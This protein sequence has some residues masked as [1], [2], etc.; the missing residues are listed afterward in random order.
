MDEGGRP[1]AMKKPMTYGEGLMSDDVFERLLTRETITRD[2]FII[3]GIFRTE[4]ARA[5]WRDPVCTAWDEAY[6]LRI[7]AAGKIAFDPAAGYWARMRTRNWKKTSAEKE[8]RVAGANPA[9]RDQSMMTQMMFQTITGLLDSPQAVRSAFRLV[10]AIHRAHHETR[11]ER[12]KRR[13]GQW[14]PI[15]L[16]IALVICVLGWILK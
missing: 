4:V 2:C 5:A 9:E 3:H 14:L 6:L 13:V 10:E 16:L 7:A 8:G 15:A 1:I 12:R 11:Q